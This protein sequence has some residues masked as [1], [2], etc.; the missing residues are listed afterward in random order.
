MTKITKKLHAGRGQQTKWE[1]PN[2]AGPEVEKIKNEPGDKEMS[3][4]GWN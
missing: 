1:I 2:K 4:C 3:V